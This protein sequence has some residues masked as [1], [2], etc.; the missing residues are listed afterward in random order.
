MYKSVVFRVLT[1]IG[2]P[3]FCLITE[4]FHYLKNPPV[5]TVSSAS[6]FLPIP[7]PWQPLTYFLNGFTYVEHFM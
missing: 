2:S 6:M 1:Q 5:H 7:A 4:H 3:Y